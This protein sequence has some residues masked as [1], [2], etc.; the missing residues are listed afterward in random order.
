MLTACLFVCGHLQ[1]CNII[2]NHSYFSLV[3][4]GIRSVA[5]GG[6]GHTATSA[7]RQTVDG[8]H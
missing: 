4:Q 8:N 3:R 6:A 5:G 7:S 1:V 2:I